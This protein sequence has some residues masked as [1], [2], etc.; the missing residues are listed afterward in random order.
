MVQI[1]ENSLELLNSDFG[2]SHWYSV[3]KIWIVTK[4]PMIYIP[5]IITMVSYVHKHLR[6]LLKLHVGP[7]SNS[8]YTCKQVCP[9]S[10]DVF[11]L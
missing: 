2:N 4:C 5:D 10:I 6:I 3:R 9:P 11:V 8:L 1:P 7:A